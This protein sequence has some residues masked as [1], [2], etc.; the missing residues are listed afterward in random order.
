[1]LALG[2]VDSSPTPPLRGSR[3]WN[4]TQPRAHLLVHPRTQQSYIYQLHSPLVLSPVAR[5]VSL[6]SSSS[7]FRRC[8]RLSSHQARC[9]GTFPAREERKEERSE[10]QYPP[11]PPPLPKLPISISLLSSRRHVHGSSN[12][13][14]SLFPRPKWNRQSKCLLDRLPVNLAAD[15]TIREHE[16]EFGNAR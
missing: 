7:E 11:P 5:L 10:R 9:C 4:I 2:C 8:S 14:L 1:M 6:F 16:W 13:T 15:E 12:L 3:S